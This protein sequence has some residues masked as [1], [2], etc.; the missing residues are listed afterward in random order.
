MKDLHICGALA[1]CLYLAKQQSFHFSAVQTGVLS[2]KPIPS[3]VVRRNSP[4]GSQQS[5]QPI[6]Q[7]VTLILTSIAASL[8]L[9][10]GKAVRITE[11]L[12]CTHPHDGSL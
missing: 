12:A 10:Q 2:L 3:E 11:F 1:D 5:L 4:K 9:D 7:V 6:L 8:E